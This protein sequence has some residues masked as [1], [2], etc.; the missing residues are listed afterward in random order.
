MM[1]GP[2]NAIIKLHAIKELKDIIEEKQV[3]L[4]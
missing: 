3:L 1:N 4:K 2:K